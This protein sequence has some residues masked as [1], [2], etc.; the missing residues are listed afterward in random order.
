[1]KVFFSKKHIVIFFAYLA[2]LLLLWNGYVSLWDQDEAAYAG[3]AK[4]MLETGNWLIPHFDWAFIHRKPPFHFW[5]M[6]VAYKIFGINTFSVRFFSA[7]AVWLSIFLLYRR[8]KKLV[9][10]ETAFLSALV[11]ASN[12]LVIM[13]G[14]MAI[15]D[16]WMLLFYTWAG[17]SLWEYFATNDNRKLWEFYTA[18]ALSFLVKG[19]PMLLFGGVLFI[20]LLLFYPD[21]KR[22]L[23]TRPWLYGI[24]SLLPF[25]LWVWLAW[26]KD[27]AFVR[28]WI[29]WYIIKRI[30]SSVLH[31]TGPPGTY[32]LLFFI[33]FLP[34]SVFVFPAVRL[35]FK[36]IR[37]RQSPW[38]FP[39]L[40]LIAGW[41]PYELLKSKLP[42]Y[43]LASYPPLAVLIAGV[44]TEFL[45]GKRQKQVR[46]IGI[47]A[48]I[49]F[50][51]A[52]VAF[53]G[54]F[55]A[56]K[57]LGEKPV[58]IPVLAVV[59]A[60]A[61][62]M[63]YLAWK[64]ARA[65]DFTIAVKNIAL[66]GIMITAGL[67]LIVL[68]LIE[69]YKNA[70][71]RTAKFISANNPSTGK[72]IVTNDFGKPP[73]LIFYL[74][75]YNPG[76]KIEIHDEKDKEAWMID[77]FPREKAVWIINPHQWEI[78]KS[79]YAGDLRQYR[80]KRF[81]SLNTGR[82]GNNDYIILIPE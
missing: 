70:G 38:L 22:L 8:V 34:F 23:R 40:W 43:V 49:M 58:A 2:V 39:A 20:L 64:S 59:F 71:F 11:L 26:K 36:S 42:A 13:L 55:I 35:A 15:T 9:N 80:M 16:A 24:L 61:G 29:D 30:H 44:L 76:D 4:R 77:R 12:L 1:M 14:K 54:F 48:I 3:F 56:A 19:P 41:L 53:S 46:W 45:K 7:L 73:S 21:E 69:P 25:F 6:S 65:N 27:P 60:T 57:I 74:E 47:Q 72:I 75:K 18:V 66:Q 10:D 50:F 5:T 79:R 78:L 52:V 67:F 82:V 81:R 33:T 51:L 28:W 62:W 37:R 32:F 68:P 17:L 63:W 31:Q